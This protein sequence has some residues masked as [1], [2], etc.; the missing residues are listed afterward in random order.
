MNQKKLTRTEKH[1]K[2][3]NMMTRCYN[4]DWQ[5]QWGE[6]YVKNG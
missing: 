4:S 6:Q 5:D 2:Y 3:N 1:R